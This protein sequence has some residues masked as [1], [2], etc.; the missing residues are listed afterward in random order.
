[1]PGVGPAER[2]T[3]GRFYV[4]AGCIGCGLC[5]AYAP[6]NLA[7]NA[8]GTRC[9]VARQPRGVRELAAVLAAAED[10]PAA[11]LRRDGDAG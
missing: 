6:A 1:M 7:W 11:C 9:F 8:A 2:D 10:C 3:T 5:P 4:T